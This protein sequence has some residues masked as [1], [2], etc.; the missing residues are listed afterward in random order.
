MNFLSSLDLPTLSED[1]KA[2]CDIEFTK[3]DLHETLTSMQGGKSPGN[4]GLTKEFYL[5]FWDLVGD[6]VYESFIEAKT[7]GTLSPSQRQALI[8]LI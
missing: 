4:D 5:H 6:S 7:K 3:D 1:Q 8:K 2:F